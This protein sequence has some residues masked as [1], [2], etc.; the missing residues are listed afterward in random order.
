MKQGDFKIDLN[1]IK[2]NESLFKIL[3]LAIYLKEGVKQTSLTACI[4]E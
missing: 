1:I 3:G 2:T 4:L